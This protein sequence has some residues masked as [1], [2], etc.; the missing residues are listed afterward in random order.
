M[1]VL[2][3]GGTGEARA[4]AAALVEDGVDVVSSLAGRVSQ[5]A[6]P[7]GAVRLGGFSDDTRDGAAGLAAYVAEQGISRVVDATHPFAAQISANAAAAAAAAGF[8]LLRL[9]R[10]GWQEHPRAGE[11]VWVPD[12][13][14]AR[15]R[16]ERS[17]IRPFLTTGRQQ[18]ETFAP[19]DDR[20]VLARVVDPPDWAVPSSWEVLRARGP[21]TYAAERALMESRRVDVVVTKDSG[22]PLTAA[23]LDAAL[24]LGL[25]V[26]VVRRPDPPSGVATCQDLDAAVLWIR[27]I[28]E[29]KVT[30]P[31]DGAAS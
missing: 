31:R 7:A 28:T 15:E 18:L 16:A 22:G 8:P 19:W 26:V 6:L 3:L 2:I 1:K 14:R 17:G 21:Y 29:G 11:L 12:V 4:L 5:P 20:Y 23:K 24:D 9:Q 13:E 25:T 27:G 10:P 30:S